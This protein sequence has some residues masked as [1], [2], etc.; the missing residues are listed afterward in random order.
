VLI[1]APPLF[2]GGDQNRFTCVGETAFATGLV[3]G[4]G[5]VAAYA[6]MDENKI[7]QNTARNNGAL[8]VKQKNAL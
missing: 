6:D 8:T 1:P 2:V 3:G 5:T 4:S 7:M